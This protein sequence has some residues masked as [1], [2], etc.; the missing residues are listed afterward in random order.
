MEK[1]IV[2][3]NIREMLGEYKEAK[4][5]S[6]VALYYPDDADVA[7]SMVELYTD[8][9]NRKEYVDGAPEEGQ[10]E[11]H[12]MLKD[13]DQRFEGMK[14]LILDLENMKMSKKALADCNKA[15]D[16]LKDEIDVL[17]SESP[18]PSP[19]SEVAAVAA[20]KAAAA[21]KA[22]AA[23]APAP[24]AA[25][26]TAVPK[27]TI[28]G[29][30]KVTTT[31]SGRVVNTQTACNVRSSKDMCEAAQRFP[32]VW[33]EGNNPPCLT[34]TDY[35]KLP[36]A[37]PRAAVSSTSSTTAT[38]TPVQRA[39]AARAPAAPAA[40]A[41]AAIVAVASHTAPNAATY[42]AV[43]GK[44]VKDIQHWIA[45]TAKGF[46]ATGILTNYIKANYQDPKGKP[47]TLSALNKP[48]LHQLLAMMEASPMSWFEE[49]MDDDEF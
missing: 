14:E 15:L 18:L 6:I 5:T 13:F 33:V 29:T 7:A 17:Q 22:V 9:D 2:I 43:R 21:P 49:I 41:A 23:P 39:R 25:A 40:A 12:E 36:G 28:A 8:D 1:D 42:R 26:A 34:G 4:V 27:A 32:C 38:V 48:E 31:A 24:K 16:T 45:D 30:R 19:P 35:K 44:T 11:F 37:V 3:D 20:P 47:K 10:E 46:G